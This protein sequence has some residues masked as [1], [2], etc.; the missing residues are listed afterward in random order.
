MG[1]TSLVTFD[2]STKELDDFKIPK[3]KADAIYY[4]AEIESFEYLNT[5]DIEGY[6]SNLSDKLGIDLESLFGDL[7]YMY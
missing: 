7:M 6:L 4:D 2:I 5:V 1:T 3:P